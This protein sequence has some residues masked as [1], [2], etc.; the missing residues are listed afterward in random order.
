M[1]QV[2]LAAKLIRVFEG[3]RLTAYEDS[4][5]VWTIGF[6]HTHN[7]IEGQV[8][9]EAEAEE[10]LGED[11]SDVVLLVRNASVVRGAA[12]ISFG[13]NCG[14]SALKR[15]LG[16]QSNMSDFVHDRHGNVLPGLVNRRGLE[17]ALYDLG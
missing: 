9:S 14:R 4:G 6:G 5:G 15:V 3:L 16:N 7:V 8:I 10:F 13:Y 17:S 11:L 12:L 1:T 2:Q